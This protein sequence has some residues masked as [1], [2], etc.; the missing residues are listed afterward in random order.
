MPLMAG[1]IPWL[2]EVLILAVQPA[3]LHGPCDLRTVHITSSAQLIKHIR[4]T[5]VNSRGNDFHMKSDLKLRGWIRAS[6]RKSEKAQREA[7][8]AVGCTAL[9]IHGEDTFDELVKELR[10]GETV[11]VTSMARISSHRADLAPARRAVHAK[12]AVIWEV[13]PL[14]RRSDNADHAADMIAD[15]VSELTGDARTLTRKDAKRNGAKGGKNKGKNAMRARTSITEAK[16][17]WYDRK[18]GTIRQRL[19]RDEMRGW[20]LATAY[21]KLGTTTR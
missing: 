5:V 2:C 21:R 10:K 16:S 13:P 7:L 14:D 18:A 6:T 20:S 19:S 3:P 1:G 15:A 4:L 9:Y 12:G 17:V 8:A 11:C